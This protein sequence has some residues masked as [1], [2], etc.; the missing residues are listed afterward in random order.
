ML[1]RFQ[2]CCPQGIEIFESVTI[3]FFQFHHIYAT[4]RGKLAFLA[5]ML[6]LYLYGSLP[7]AK[8]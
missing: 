8:S 6:L 4:F 7:N 3:I 1:V 2:E 5:T